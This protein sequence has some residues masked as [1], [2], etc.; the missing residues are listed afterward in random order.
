MLKMYTDTLCVCVCVYRVVAAVVTCGTALG[1]A[2]SF[3][4]DYAK[5]K[6]AAAQL[7]ALLD[8]VPK[9]NTNPA[10]GQTWVRDKDRESKIEGGSVVQR[11]SIGIM[12][13]HGQIGQ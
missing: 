5:A 13:D 3:T 2:S 6:I 10:E 9:I 7:F 4:P 12:A 1:K 8:R 11:P